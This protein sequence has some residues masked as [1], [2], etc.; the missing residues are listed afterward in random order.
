MSICFRQKE[1][2]RTVTSQQRLQEEYWLEKE[3]EG[4]SSWMFIPSTITTFGVFV[5]DLRSKYDAST[6]QISWI[7]AISCAVW[8][9]SA[10]FAA[11]CLSLYSH[12]RLTI[13]GSVL[14]VIGLIIGAFAESLMVVYISFGVLAGLGIAFASQQGILLVQEYFQEKRALANGI[15]LAG[16]SIGQMIVP[17]LLQIFLLEYGVSGTM[18]LLS[19]IAMQGIIAG[20]LFQPSRWHLRYPD[21]I[22]LPLKYTKLPGTDGTKKN[23][24]LDCEGNDTEDH[25]KEIMKRNFDL[26]GS[27]VDIHNMGS[28]HSLSQ[29]KANELK[30]RRRPIPP[31]KRVRPP[32]RPLWLC[33]LPHFPPLHALF[34]FALVKNVFFVLCTVSTAFGRFVYQEVNTLVP[35]MAREMGISPGNSA[36]LLSLLA[37]TDTV[38]RL[39]VPVLSEKIKHKVSRIQIYAVNYLVKA[40][41]CLGIA[42]ATDYVTLATFCCIYGVGMGGNTGISMI[43][44]AENLGLELLP[45]AFGLS[46]GFNAIIYFGGLPLIGAIR[47]VTGSYQ[48]C[49]IVMAGCL[50]FCFLIWLILPLSD[51]IKRRKGQA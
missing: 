33:W 22:V 40:V 2:L 11:G 15:M 3:V 19:G 16:A 23:N 45:M 26:A 28:M 25:E 21:I 38:A 27:L 47:D 46:L 50:I 12:R 32:P 39:V 7:P 41:A 37:L 20:A 13:F 1:V 17:I 43:I 44:M 29:M 31:S 30:K 18:L 42:F 4:L 34:N 8:N 49:F 24:Q 6:S 10:P 48:A 36:A 51:W 9:L 14:L 35:P 5:P